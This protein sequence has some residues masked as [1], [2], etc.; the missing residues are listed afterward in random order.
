MTQDEIIEACYIDHEAVM[1]RL[2]DVCGL[3]GWSGMW[4]DG[5]QDSLVFRLSV[6]F[7]M[8]WLTQE[9]DGIREPHFRDGLKK[10]AS[11]FGDAFG[12]PPTIYREPPGWPGYVVGDDGSVWSRC[13][14]GRW[15]R[16]A[17]WR[18]L[19][20]PPDNYGYAQVN[21]NLL[22]KRSH[23]LVHRLVMLTFVGPK[24]SGLCIR[25]LNG[26]RSDNRLVNLAYGTYQENAEDTIRHGRTNRGSKTHSCKLSEDAVR[27]IRRLSASG[28]EGQ[29]IAWLFGVSPTT[30]CDILA[31]RTWAWVLPE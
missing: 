4:A 8:N 6:R 11:K 18:R 25:H 24:P 27:D 16:M 31:G 2:D 28:E 23:F 13:Q 19:R 1:D 26:D 29:V 22:G 30:V 7:G 21:I 3:G 10:A 14:Q 15:F 5:E 12:I 17:E 9:A 20:T